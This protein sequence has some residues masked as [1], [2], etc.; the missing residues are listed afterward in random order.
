MKALMVIASLLMAA[1]PPPPPPEAP[2]VAQGEFDG[3]AGPSLWH[4]WQR[5][6]YAAA[7]TGAQ[8]LYHS[9][10]ADQPGAVIE[11]AGPRVEQWAPYYWTETVRF[12][13]NRVCDG[14]DCQWRFH[15]VTLDRD[16]ELYDAVA[17]RLFDG[18][19]AAAYLRAQGI[20]PGYDIPAEHR[21]MGRAAELVEG[22]S[23][24]IRFH[25]QLESEC[26]AVADWQARFE[27]QNALRSDGPPLPPYPISIDVEIM[28]P[29]PVMGLQ[30]D[31]LTLEGNRDRALIELANALP[32][33]LE[34]CYGEG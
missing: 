23:E 18:T 19:A 9:Y 3:Y 14:P 32:P 11:R 16:R 21:A 12:A 10:N 28:V 22:V 13:F 20:D 30:E 25:V 15:R 24:H 6:T 5:A 31:W 33:P 4:A 17:E 1:S 29:G 27:L 26:A 7:A 2:E 8:E 34:V